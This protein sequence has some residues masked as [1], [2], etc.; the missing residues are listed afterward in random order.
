MLNDLVLRNFRSQ[1]FVAINEGWPLPTKENEFLSPNPVF[2]TYTQFGKELTPEFIDDVIA[3]V[4]ALPAKLPRFA[5]SEVVNVLVNTKRDGVEIMV[6]IRVDAMAEPEHH[7]E[8]SRW[9]DFYA[10]RWILGQVVTFKQRTM[11]YGRCVVSPR[12]VVHSDSPTIE[13]AFDKLRT[14]VFVMS[15]DAG[16]SEEWV[17]I[18]FGVLKTV[19]GFRVTCMVSLEDTTEEDV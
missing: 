10:E 15:D 12:E 18:E 3:N 9:R 19:D 4:E 8:F 1:V 5:N 2:K 6:I 11:N 7:T 17:P 14:T 16:E 13:E